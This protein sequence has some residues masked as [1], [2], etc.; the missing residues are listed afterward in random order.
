MQTYGNPDVSYD[1]WAGNARFA[2]LSGFFIAAHVGQV[3]LISLWAGAFTPFGLFCGTQTG[4]NTEPIVEAIQAEFGGD[5][6]FTH[7]LQKFSYL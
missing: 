3:A 5:R 4:G 2:D 7:N 1:W 6:I